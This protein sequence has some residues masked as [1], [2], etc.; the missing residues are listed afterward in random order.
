MHTRNKSFWKHRGGDFGAVRFGAL[1]LGRESVDSVGS[2]SLLQLGAL[3][4]FGLRVSCFNEQRAGEESQ[5][6]FSNA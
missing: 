5:A 3:V 4:E 1:P 2:C 6:I